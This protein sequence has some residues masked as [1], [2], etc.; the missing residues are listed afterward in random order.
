MRGRSINRGR[1]CW[2][3]RLLT[4]D[5]LGVLLEVGVFFYLAFAWMSR[6]C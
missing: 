4:L 3:R 1:G 5:V 6:N 2:Y